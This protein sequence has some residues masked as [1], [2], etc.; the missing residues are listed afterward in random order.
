VLFEVDVL[1]SQANT[2][3]EAQAGAVENFAMSW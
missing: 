1:D 2:F 3:N